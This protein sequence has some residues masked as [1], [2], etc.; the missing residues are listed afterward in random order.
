MDIFEEIF[1]YLD[2]KDIL[3]L[4]I[5]N[6]MNYEMITKSKIYCDW[7]S[8]NNYKNTI[9]RNLHYNLLDHYVKM[10]MDKIKFC[11]QLYCSY[12]IDDSDDEY[13]T[14]LSPD[15][16]NKLKYFIKIFCIQ[17]NTK[18]FDKIFN[19]IMKYV[20]GSSDSIIK[21]I[22]ITLSKYCDNI[23]Y[24]G[25]IMTHKR[26]DQCFGHDLHNVN[27]AT[28]CKNYDIFQEFQ[29]LKYPIRFPKI[30]GTLCKWKNIKLLKFIL[31]TD[32]SN[33][34]IK[35]IIN[36]IM[37]QNDIYNVNNNTHMRY[38]SKNKNINY[39]NATIFI[40]TLFDFMDKN[41]VLLYTFRNKLFP[42]ACCNKNIEYIKNIFD[43][44]LLSNINDV[45][46][47]LKISMYR[48]NIFPELLLFLKQYINIENVANIL[49]HAIHSNKIDV[50]TFIKKT[51]Y[52]ELKIHYANIDGKI[53]LENI[54]YT[55]YFY[56]IFD[57]FDYN[58]A[59]PIF[60]EYNLGQ[61]TCKINYC[62][63][64]KGFIHKLLSG[65]NF[66][67]IN[68]TDHLRILKMA[69]LHKNYYIL[70]K[71][72]KY[73]ELKTDKNNNLI[74]LIIF[75]KSINADTDVIVNVCKMV[76]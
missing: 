29:K 74:D 7:T 15:L 59:Y 38:L 43:K 26:Y 76:I 39:N 53:I 8:V 32:S 6:K 13:P 40:T 34:H 30:I 63:Y 25:I 48:K 75:L 62:K 51:Y 68:K 24:F 54:K 37:D 44:S 61:N 41:N 11:R 65:I 56:R 27:M 17:N 71:Y 42:I 4:V 35:Q 70:K 14:M 18:I 31:D 21:I 47:G 69:C 20:F 33:V 9:D 28:Y 66:T 57:L 60:L 2:M 23:K 19:E 1:L 12:D 64:S 22:S 50:V 3:S 16:Q 5:T 55:N 52:N 67:N 58:I 46:L 49:E 73:E 36:K 72:D 10:I 45:I